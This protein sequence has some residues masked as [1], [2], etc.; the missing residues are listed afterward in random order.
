MSTFKALITEA[1]KNGAYY[2]VK[3][4][5]LPREGDRITLHSFVDA[6]N[7]D[8]PHHAYEVV[9]VVHEIHDIPED[10][11]KHADGYHVVTVIVKD[12]SKSLP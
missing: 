4:G 2:R 7:G 8:D 3:L 10:D 9:G 11:P 1:E 12:L 5:C 6:K